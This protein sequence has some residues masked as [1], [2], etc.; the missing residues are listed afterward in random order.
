M[1]SILTLFMNRP[2]NWREVVIPKLQTREF[3]IG[4]GLGAFIVVIACVALVA[5][6]VVLHNRIDA[7]GQ[8][9]AEQ[10]KSLADAKRV[11]SDQSVALVDAKK[12]GDAALAT[13]AA[14]V[15]DLKASVEAFALQAASCEQ[16]KRQ[17]NTGQLNITEAQ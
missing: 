3:A 11:M 15:A 9:V 16:V 4:A 2:S 12:R 8:T 6:A 1:P 13:A 5:Y 7:F 17:L 10:T 14:Q